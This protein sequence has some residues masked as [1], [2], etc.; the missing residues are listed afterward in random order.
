MK[1]IDSIALRGKLVF[2]RVDLNSPVTPEGRVERSARIVAHAKTITELAEKGAKVVVLA[3]QGRK[4]DPDFL[5]LEQHYK[6][7]RELVPNEIG[8]YFVS[9]VVGHAAQKAVNSLKNGEV[10]LLDN[11]RSLDD[12]KAYDTPEECAKATL[13][14]TYEN[15]VDVFV[16]DAFSVAHRNQPSVT[17][18]YKKGIV[19]G[20]ILQAELESVDKMANFKGTA[21][22]ILGGSK[23]EDGIMIMK[24]WFGKL[25]NKVS[26]LLG[27]A[28]GNLFLH[29]K[30]IDVGRATLDFLEKN[31]SLKYVEDAKDLF[32]K[33]NAN[34]ILP[35]DVVCTSEGQILE[36]SVTE[37]PKDG[38][39]MDI[40]SKT[41]EIFNKH[42][43][44]A[45]RIMV[46][47]PLGVYEQLNFANGTREVLNAVA[48]SGAFSL[49]GG[50][51]TV[52]AIE[53]FGIN[54]KNFGYI[55]LAGKALV[56][57]LCGEKLA[58]IDLLAK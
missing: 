5:T 54:K 20:R 29:A 8:F 48:N 19:A 58:G 34:I 15:V 14:K 16:L 1:T 17:G 33:F 21:L 52:S 47:G 23:V 55:S 6:I 25:G 32:A 41:V 56:Q 30:G 53:K 13:V 49:I 10:L 46:N 40:G 42:I 50:G 51:H 38:S 43:A 4:G 57:Y 27:G 45:S 2:C 12:E 24:H 39:V 7:L 18:F 28:I 11:V 26:F 22:F 9:D 35:V 36:R 37:I 31:G 44:K 3:H